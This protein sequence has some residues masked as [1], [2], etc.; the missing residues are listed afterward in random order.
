MADALRGAALVRVTGAEPWRFLDRCAGEGIVLEDVRASDAFT[1]TARLPAS[2]AAAAKRIAARCGCELTVLARRGLPRLRS[3]ARR[4]RL[5][6]AGLAA[7][8]AALLVSWLFVWDISVTENDSH[9]PDAQILRVLASQ[10]VGVGS[11]WPAFRGERIRTRALL[12]LPELSFLAVNVRGSAAYVEVRAAKPAP[13]IFDVKAPAD[14]TAARPG[15]IASITVLA[16]SA[17][18][19]RGDAVSAEEV[20]IA[21]TDASP[22]AR[23]E[24]SAYTWYE[25]TAA[26]PLRARRTGAP[27]STKTRFALILGTKRINFYADSGILPNGCVRMSKTYVPDGSGLLRLP[28]RF[29]VETVQSVACED[30]PLSEET[31]YDS[32]ADA[33]ETALDSRLDENG[34]VLERHWSASIDGEWMYV[35]LRAACLER[36]DA[37]TPR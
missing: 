22:H 6:L 13:E 11:F 23:G 4:S 9:V 20:L 28:V 24:V 5:L 18:V 14:V 33:L 27:M 2:N 7:A 10:G 19:R 35:T 8:F 32:L 26:A 31:V 12:E 34:R 16:G 29:V 3:R 1:V 37:N 36:I 15:V 21:G 25:L 17:Q 30:E